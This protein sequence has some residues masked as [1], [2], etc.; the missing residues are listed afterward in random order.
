M[1]VLGVLF[2]L[3]LAGKRKKKRGRLQADE[4]RNRMGG[5]WKGRVN[6][7][8]GERVHEAT[9][10]VQETLRQQ[11]EAWIREHGQ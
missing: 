8:S 1:L 10:G 4:R 5:V 9:L 2:V 11:E 6:G 7:L 3:M